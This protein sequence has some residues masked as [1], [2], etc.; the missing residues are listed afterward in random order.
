MQK[1]PF[2]RV[3][4]PEIDLLFDMVEEDQVDRAVEYLSGLSL[5]SRTS[6]SFKIALSAVARIREMSIPVGLASDFGRAPSLENVRVSNA[7]V[8]GMTAALLSCGRSV[9]ARRWPCPSCGGMGQRVGAA[10]LV[11]RGQ[12]YGRIYFDID[13]LLAPWSAKATALEFDLLVAHLMVERNMRAPVAKCKQCDLFYVDWPYDPNIVNDFYTNR[14]TNG[15]VLNGVEVSGR[16]HIAAFV[17]SKIAIPLHIEEIVGGFH[18]KTIFDLGCAEGIMLE[19]FRHLG[20]DVIGSDVDRGKVAYARQVFNLSTVDSRPDAIDHQESHSL[21]V[22]VS[23]HTLEHLIQVGPWLSSMTNALRPGGHLV[24]SVPNVTLRPNGEL[25]EM[26]GDHLIGFDVASLRRHMEA[27]GLGIVDVR[28]D[29]GIAPLTDADP[30][31]GL[32][33]WSGRRADVTMV[34]QRR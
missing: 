29:D 3:L 22:L 19:A 8:Q 12:P 2:S 27:Q 14:K 23:Y 32:P 4:G 5:D 15:M 13:Q 10:S 34:A 9:V 24:I 26:G 28:S 17:Y 31:L 1:N 20:A 33:T 7:D 16:G 30:I 21:D 11:G 25:V 6:L 18:G